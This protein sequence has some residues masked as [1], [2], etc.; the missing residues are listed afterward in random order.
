MH[1]FCMLL[2]LYRVS[3]PPIYAQLFNAVATENRMKCMLKHFG[4][5][6]ARIRIG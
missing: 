3:P 1:I 5:S 2:T 6:F 4:L